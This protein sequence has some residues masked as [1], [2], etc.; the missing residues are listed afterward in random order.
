MIIKEFSSVFDICLDYVLKTLQSTW[1][2]EGRGWLFTI[3]I[4]D[5]GL[6][7]VKA[8]DTM[9]CSRHYSITTAVHISKFKVK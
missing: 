2:K 4:H 1:E 5:S 3:F 7:G 8:L 6:L 9:F